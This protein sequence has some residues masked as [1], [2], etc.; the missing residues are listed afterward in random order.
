MAYWGYHLILDCAECDVN[1][2]TDG[3]NIDRKST[4]LNSS[5]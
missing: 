4:R 2:I 1:A 5:H 3:V